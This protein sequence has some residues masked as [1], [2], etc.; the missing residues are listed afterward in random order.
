[1]DNLVS[2][3]IES[4]FNSALVYQLIFEE[5]T[6]K[7]KLYSEFLLLFVILSGLFKWNKIQIQNPNLFLLNQTMPHNS[8]IMKKPKFLF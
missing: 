5:K 1:M 7:R 3:W 6:S 4:V 8:A 2:L